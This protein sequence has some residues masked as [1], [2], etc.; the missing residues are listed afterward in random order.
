[1]TTFGYTPSEYLVMVKISKNKHLLVEGKS[2]KTAFS[3]FFDE[4]Y[5][6][7]EQS[8]PRK[9][10][11]IDSVE[12]IVNVGVF[13]NREKVEKI[14]EEFQKNLDERD[15]NNLVG[16][17]DREFRGFE[18]ND[19]IKDNINCHYVADKIVWSRGHSIENYYFELEI[20]REP[21]RVHTDIDYFTSAL[22]RF[23]N[24][25]DP[26]LQIAC[27]LSL[28]SEEMKKINQIQKVLS[29]EMII[30]DRSNIE[31]NLLKL[32]K[33]LLERHIFSEA[34]IEQF[35]KR[36]K[37]WLN[38]VSSTKKDYV[39]WMTHGHISIR[40]IW[41]VYASCVFASIS[42]KGHGGARSEASKVLKL[43][44]E[45]RFRSCANTWTH[46]ALEKRCG[47][48][49]EVFLLLGLSFTNH[50]DVQSLEEIS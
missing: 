3:Y 23:E 42:D 49:E 15:E 30:L 45:E 16:F 6:F 22:E 29:W 33:S 47:Y 21:F 39:R 50:S 44:E 20:L 27:A 2:D 35:L 28:V 26:T 46:K 17:V 10:I 1:M 19:S 13:S 36:Y 25:L 18:K 11:D 4:L 32:Q 7:K 9:K 8:I 37:F 31:I 5:R 40:L 43:S 41:F 38:K 14:C 12:G 48:P 34:E 24:I